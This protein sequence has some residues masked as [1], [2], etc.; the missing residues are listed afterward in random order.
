MYDYP[1]AFVGTQTSQF[2]YLEHFQ[3]FAGDKIDFIEP[4]LNFQDSVAYL[5]AQKGIEAFLRKI[6]DI[7]ELAKDSILP[8][9]ICWATLEDVAI[10]NW[11]SRLS[12]LLKLFI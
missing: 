8:V 11:L 1:V 10:D 5:Q 2:F 6:K 12:Y 9:R 7:I 4:A 3:S